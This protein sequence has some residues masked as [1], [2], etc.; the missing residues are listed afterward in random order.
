MKPATPVTMTS[1]TP[2]SSR[3]LKLY[4]R[5]FL[6]AMAAGLAGAG[7]GLGAGP[8]MADQP[9]AWTGITVEVNADRPVVTSHS[10]K[11]QA[12]GFH[13]LSITLSN[14]GTQPLTLERIAVRIP[15]AGPLTNDLEVLYGGSC[16]GQTPVLRQT[17]GAP[18]QLSSSYMYTMVRLADGQYLLA[19]SLSWR[20]FLPTFT[21][22]DGAFVVWSHGEGKQLEPGQTIQYEQI[23]LRLAGNWLDL[24]NAFGT[25]IASENGI[26][27]LK[28]ADFRGWATW[29]YYAYVFSAGDIRDNTGKIKALSPA[30][31]LVQIDAGW[32][33]TRG[34]Y[35]VRTDLAGGM[36]EIAD[37][38]KA[39]GMTPGIWI[40]GF[41]ANSTSE[42]CTQH[43]E[44]FL[45]DQDGNLII[46][47]RRKEGT[48]RDRVYIDYSHPGARAHIAQRIRA[49]VQDWGFPYIKIDFM[50]FGLN[51]EIMRNKP[52]VRRIKAFDPAI[53]DVERMRLGLQAMRDAVGPDNYLLGCSAVFGPCIGYVDGMRTGGDISPRYE[54]F[55]ERS[56]ANLGHFYLSGK[57]FNADADYLAFREAADEDEKVSKE[58]VKHGGS[59][60]MNEAQMWADLNKLYGSC[61]LS[62]DNLMTLRPERQAL[63][64][65][66]FQYPVMDE[67]VPLDIWRRAAGRADGFELVLARKG[68]AILS[69]RVQ[70]E[71]HAEGV[72]A[73]GVR[74]TR[75]HQ[76]GRPPFRDR[77][78]RGERF[79][80]PTLSEAPITMMSASGDRVRRGR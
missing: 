17:I 73:A 14:N 4:R 75:A 46:E 72:R 19:G 52:A 61:R 37:R 13:R 62:S 29:D 71:R 9:Q 74:E 50:R 51:Q 8:V 43:P 47:V 25:A 6:G 45:H 59:L 65:E 49:I 76:A 32:Y 80:R 30:A 24:L 11:A 39:A 44:Y 68:Q 21:I 34:D 57:V 67:T 22:K 63:V 42:V 36:K 31:N 56:L 5:D 7:L 53:T 20:V 55:P 3:E 77:Q 28:H 18:T 48:D 66:V 12:D 40:D 26:G 1:A 10:L 41:R 69:R 15:V 64:K 2:E 78:I 54:A 35:T 16:M 27:T 58:A 38:I 23:V 70:L 60:T 33:G 79:V